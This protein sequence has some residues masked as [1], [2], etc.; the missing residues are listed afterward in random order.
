MGELIPTWLLY[1]ESLSDH[2]AYHI[3]LWRLRLPRRPLFYHAIVNSG[4][5]ELDSCAL[6]HLYEAVKR[7]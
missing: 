3:M 1:S 6:K 7:G 2:M 5:S 4:L